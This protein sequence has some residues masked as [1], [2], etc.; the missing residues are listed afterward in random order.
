VPESAVIYDSQKRASV[1]VPDKDQKS[2]KH[3]V[4]VTV[5]LSNGSVTEILN[6]LNEGSQVVLQQ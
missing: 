6:G 4:S 5:G 3:K 1:E 2:G